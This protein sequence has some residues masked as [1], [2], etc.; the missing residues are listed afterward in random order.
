MDKKHFEIQVMHN[1]F[2]R[3]AIVSACKI[4]L[5]TIAYYFVLNII[6]WC[7]TTAITSASGAASNSTKIVQAT[8]AISLASGFFV[9]ITAVLYFIIIISIIVKIISEHKEVTKAEEA[10][11]K[12]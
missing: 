12:K 9:A 2:M 6:G 5:W 1:H 10:L 8:E 11:F 4:V 3:T 7:T